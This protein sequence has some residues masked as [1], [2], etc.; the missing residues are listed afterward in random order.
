MSV[1]NKLLGMS[2][3]FSSLT[4]G[5]VRY[6]DARINGDGPLPTTLSGPA[7]VHGDADGKYN[8][9][10]DLLSGITPYAMP[11]T[12]RMGSDRNYQQ[13]PHRKQ[14]P[15]PP[16]Y[17][18]EPATD[19]TSSFMVSHP[20]DM[21]DLVFIINLRNKHTML[22]DTTTT[23]LTIRN[24]R[25]G[26]IM[27]QYNV[28]CNICTANYLL[29]GIYNYIIEYVYTGNVLIGRNGK[30]VKHH[31]WHL[32]EN[33]GIDKEV[34]D[35][36]NVYHEASPHTLVNNNK[37]VI[38]LKIKTM[39]QKVVRNNIVPIGISVMSEKQGGQHE[40]GLGPVQAAASFY[41]TL[42][43]DG[44]NRDL[45]NIWRHVSLEGG[46]YL[47]VR[48]DF[49][50]TK[51]EN[52]EYTVNHYYKQMH[53]RSIRMYSEAEGRFQLVPDVFQSAHSANLKGCLHSSTLMDK[54]PRTTTLSQSGIDAWTKRKVN[55]WMISVHA[56]ADPHTA[57][58]IEPKRELLSN[59]LYMA[60]DYKVAGFWHIGQT[61]TKKAS[62]SSDMCPIDDRAICSDGS[63]LLQI[64]FAPV[65]K[66]GLQPT[67]GLPQF[68]TGRF[69]ANGKEIKAL[70]FKK[71]AE[72]DFDVEVSKTNDTIHQ[73]LLALTLHTSNPDILHSYFS[74]SLK[75]GQVV[76]QVRNIDAV[77]SLFE[78]MIKIFG[79]VHVYL[80]ARYFSLSHIW[81][82]ISFI[83]WELEGSRDSW[84]AYK[85]A[86]DWDSGREQYPYPG[87]AAPANWGIKTDN[88]TETALQNA[89]DAA[90]A[91][92]TTSATRKSCKE[93]ELQAASNWWRHLLEDK[94]T[95]QKCEEIIE[96]FDSIDIL[97]FPDARGSAGNKETLDVDDKD[98]ACFKQLDDYVKRKKLKVTGRFVSDRPNPKNTGSGTQLDKDTMLNYESLRKVLC[99]YWKHH[100]RLLITLEVQ[101]LTNV[102]A[103]SR[104]WFQAFIE[105]PGNSLRTKL[106][107][108]FRFFAHNAA[109]AHSISA[110]TK[111]V[112]AADWQKVATATDQY[113]Q[114]I[115]ADNWPQVLEIHRDSFAPFDLMAQLNEGMAASGDASGDTLMQE[116]VLSDLPNEQSQQLQQAPLETGIQTGVQ[117][118]AQAPDQEPPKKKGR[119]PLD[120]KTLASISESVDAEMES[121]FNSVTTGATVASK[122]SGKDGNGGKGK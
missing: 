59:A 14:F 64:N 68:A 109:T 1:Y 77:A 93:D 63:Q 28:F 115:T 18:P 104:K 19:A 102:A 8:F 98:I 121:I 29:A 89:V 106:F 88:L 103:D 87:G 37:A 96:Y 61:Y 48:L 111:P 101:A 44:Q 40:V 107:G 34:D 5:N 99:F 54:N 84:E 82:L 83:G 41:T 24:D 47:I 3:F 50:E 92:F 51:R 11:G 70:V 67:M 69:D 95:M 71:W 85:P 110:A 112:T 10:N 6:P 94:R 7:G 9:N 17:L 79:R 23:C 91:H 21:G 60:L 36:F 32:I 26:G 72:E 35:L 45:V 66:H 105:Q 73:R 42:T 62:F 80:G 76:G 97:L 4:Q 30:R 38:L 52:W 46:D 49:D 108:F 43:V 57:A 74:N 22:T 55:E 90:K 65:Y 56:A 16:I 78:D 33:F 114:K 113:N 100:K 116:A 86:L 119:K 58:M 117:A 27:P 12:G 39:L 31:W 81:H 20:I 75:I 15:V 2:D 25:T 13:I 118:P 120:K 53:S 122:E